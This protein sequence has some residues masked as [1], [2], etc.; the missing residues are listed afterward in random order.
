MLETIERMSTIIRARLSAQPN[1]GLPRDIEGRNIYL[2]SP[3]YIASYARRFIAH[4][5]RLVGGCCGTTPEH[6]R[7]IKNA[8]KALAPEVARASARARESVGAPPSA[9]VDADAGRCRRN[10][11]SQ[12]ARALA[13]GRFATIVELMP[14]KG[15]VSEAIIEQARSLKIRGVDVVHIPDGPA[16]RA[17]ERALAG[18]ADAAAR[19]DRN[20]APVLVPRPQPA[21]HAVGSARRARDGRAQPRARHRRRPV[22]RRLSGRHRRVRRR[23]D[24]PDQRRHP[25][26]SGSRHRRAG[27]SAARRRFTSA[28]R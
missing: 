10:E 6:I 2:S 24:R 14:P 9:A 23:F 12:L 15:Y 22:G 18:R 27:R 26:Q 11:R 28:C 1:A 17:H 19:V 16:R 13:E 7:Q 20:G 4:G 25:A 3:E 5:V 8:V 21:R